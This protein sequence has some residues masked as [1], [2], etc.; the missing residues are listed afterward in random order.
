MILSTQQ[1]QQI[2]S[3]INEDNEIN[4]RTASK[5]RHDIYKD[6]G[7]AFLIEQIKKEFGQDALK[8]MRLAPINLLKKI[9]NKRAS[10]YARPATR[11]ANN[12]QNQRLVDYYSRKLSIDQIMQKCNRYS[13]LLANTVLYT[14]P[15]EGYVK[16]NVIPSYLYSIVP[17]RLDQTKIDG[18]VFNAFA[19]EGRVT[20]ETAQP[21]A[22]GQE[23]AKLDTGTKQ[24]GQ[25]V[26]S[27]EQTNDDARLYVFW[28]D[29]EHVTVNTKG[30]ALGLMSDVPTEEQIKNPI[31]M[32]PV[33]NVAKDRDNEPWATQGEDLVDLTMAIQMGWTDVMTIAKHQGFS[34]LTVISEE[35]PTKLTLGI[36]KAVW[37]KQMDGKPEP[38]I[39]YVTGNSPLDQYKELLG[40][41]L[42]LLLTTNDMDPS[43]IGGK[44]ASKQFTSGFHALISM[45]DNLQA[46]EQ[47]KPLMEEAEH[48][49]WEVI[50]R[51]HNYLI[52]SKLIRDEEARSL[53]KFTEDFSITIQ[54]ASVRP[55]ESEDEIVGRVEKLMNMGLIDRLGA[56]KKLNPNM[57]DEEILALDARI[58]V[59]RA[60]EVKA[61]MSPE[62]E[63]SAEDESEDA[64][65]EEM[66]GEGKV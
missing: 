17:N 7:R 46:I 50:K 54:F 64:S 25:L 58:S 48:R 57:D 8:E 4:R 60:K 5:R 26:D 49:N 35:E 55:L 6:G 32:S 66:N 39:S 3:E 62:K 45:A 2:I 61:I 44:M 36:N 56:L 27:Q 20:P 14:R 21:S 10:I 65:E 18:F 37:L 12:P 33:T 22:T 42:G 31:L 52:D 19:E 29:L 38:K 16:C 51:W 41:L 28:T 40:E 15:M 9:V 1:I 13:T 11:K 34:I 30:E 24:L 59:E 53:G 47:D 63:D 43:T 23:N